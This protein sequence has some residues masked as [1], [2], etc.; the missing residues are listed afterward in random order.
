MGLMTIFETTEGMRDAIR[1]A[2]RTPRQRARDAERGRASAAW[3]V[4]TD[5]RNALSAIP[6]P[7]GRYDFSGYTCP[8][9]AGEA[10][11]G[12]KWY[13]EPGTWFE[14]LHLRLRCER[15]HQW[16]IDTDMG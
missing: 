4:E 16:S 12:W 11:G 3:R 13:S 5:L 6:K 15:R 7:I 14:R 10:V 9:C 1:R 8:A 2:V